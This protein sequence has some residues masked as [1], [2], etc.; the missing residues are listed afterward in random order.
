M[1]LAMIA[2]LMAALPIGSAVLEFTLT[3]G[4]AGWL[5]LLGK[6]FV[7]WAVGIRLLVAGARQVFT[8]ALSAEMRQIKDPAAQRMVRE[9]GFGNLAIGA[10]GALSLPLPGWVLS[11]AMCGGLFYGFAGVQH[12]LMRGRSQAENWTLASNLFVFLVLAVYIG[13]DFLQR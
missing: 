12:L 8:P 1:Y 2:M 13:A 5:P 4:A 10:T 9:L 3:Q 7:F 6:W 11:A